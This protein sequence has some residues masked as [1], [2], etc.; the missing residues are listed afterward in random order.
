MAKI[1]L[2]SDSADHMA[3]DNCRMTFAISGA[4]AE[5]DVIRKRKAGPQ[6]KRRVKKVSR[7]S[8]E[9]ELGSVEPEERRE[10]DAQSK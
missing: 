6:A 7:P 4:T 5:L 8:F 1:T 9:D 2:H 10:P 3:S